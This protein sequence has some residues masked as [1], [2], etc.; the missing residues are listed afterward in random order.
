[1]CHNAHDA[2]RWGQKLASKIGMG[3]VS[4]KAGRAL[5]KIRFLL[6]APSASQM[7]EYHGKSAPDLSRST[8]FVWATA[9]LVLN[10][11]LDVIRNISGTSLTNIFTDLAA[12]GIFQYMA[13]YVIFWLLVSGDRQLAARPRDIVICALVSLLVAVPTSRSI[14]IAATGI[15]VYLCAAGTDD[16]KFSAAGVVLAALSIQEFWGHVFFELVTF[17]LLRAETAIVG[18]LLKVTRTGA[19]WKDNIIT[20]PSGHAIIILPFCSSFHNLSLALL[21]WVTVSRLRN[22][23]WRALDF[24]GGVIVGGAMILY[25]V[26]RL[27]LMALNTELYEYWHQGTGVEIFAV[28]A[29]LTV[30]FLSFMC[31]R[32][33]EIRV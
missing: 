14:W 21:C 5:G 23:N 33:R 17:P 16:R 22:Q 8:V 3:P 12:V 24:I 13:W 7:K 28:G 2:H 29:S 15:A 26:V 31:S 32:R 20:V 4:A 1:L 18:T 27:Y 9:I 6:L 11:I 30:L 19:A 10:Q 25:N